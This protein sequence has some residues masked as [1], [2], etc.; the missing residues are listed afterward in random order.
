MNLFTSF[1]FHQTVPLNLFANFNMEVLNT[2]LH[3]LNMIIFYESVG[4]VLENVWLKLFPEVYQSVLNKICESFCEINFK[5][6][7]PFKTQ[8]VTSMKVFHS[9]KGLW[10]LGTCRNI[11]SMGEAKFSLSYSNSKSRV[12]RF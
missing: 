10:S 11:H 2:F 3:L 7:R 1:A 12:I 5:P 6:S 8:S 9:P 4:S